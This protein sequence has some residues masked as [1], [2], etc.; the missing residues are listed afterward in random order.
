MTAARTTRSALPRTVLALGLTSFFTDVGS[1]MVFPLLPV[2][3]VS[4]GAGPAFLG[5][6]E[7]VADAVSSLLKLA[8]GHLSDRI[9][10]RKPFVLLGYS[11]AGAVRPLM[12][13]ATAPWHVLGIRGTDRVG[14]GI[15]TAPRD[16]LIA[17]SV[18][19]ESAGRAFGFHRAMDHLGAVVGPLVATGLLGLGWTVRGVFLATIVPGA[20][21]VACVLVIR[22]ARAGGSPRSGSPQSPGRLPRRLHA[23]VAILGL[24]ALG[25]SSDAF[26]LLRARETGVGVAALPLLWAAF[27]VVKAALSYF[28]GNWSDRLPRVQLITCGWM[29]YALAYLGFG[30]ARS[31][32]HAWALFVVYGAYYGLT[33]PVE[34]ALVRDLAPVEVRGRA[35]GLYHFVVG[36]VAVPAGLLVGTLWQAWGA[37]IALGTGAALAALSSGALVLWARGGIRAL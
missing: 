31:P 16:V 37:P 19:S 18:P 7:G 13:L 10:W 17:A 20:F 3:V 34:R 23:Y 35:F 4:L 26:L 30:L 9:R 28:A 2:F 6:V 8:S 1:E 33:E 27:H 15:R 24:F 36:I 25:N 5:L 21:A 32:W 11:L 29:V 14:K 22:E 12:G